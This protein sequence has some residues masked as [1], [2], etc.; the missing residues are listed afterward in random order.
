[1]DETE[2]EY[3]IERARNLSRELMLRDDNTPVEE[4]AEL[5]AAALF[6]YKSAILDG[7]V[8]ADLGDMERVIIATYTE[9]LACLLRKHGGFHCGRSSSEL[10]SRALTLYANDLAEPP[11]L[12]KAA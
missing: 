4:D 11:A 10:C 9:D 8:A 7:R 2:I 6:K 3:T 12:A 5:C 1:M